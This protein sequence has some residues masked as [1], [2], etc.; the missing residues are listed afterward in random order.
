M[1]KPEL[2]PRRPWKGAR[3]VLGVTGG[4]AAYKSV[5][6]ARDLSRLGAT[7]QVVQS[8]GSRNFVQPLSFEAVTGRPVHTDLFETS[9]G[10]SRSEPGGRA[11]GG[12]ALHIRLGHDADVVC[13]APATADFLARAGTGRAD[14]LLTTTLLVTRAPVVLCPAMNDRMWAHPSTTSNVAR[15]QELGYRI[16]GPGVGPLAYG[17]GEGPGRMLEPAE[18]VEQVGRALCAGDPLGGRRVLVTAGPTREPVDA[19][20]YVGNRSSGRMGFAVARA[21]WRRGADVML[22]TGPS[23]LGDP[24]GVRVVRVESAREMD[25]A[26]RE[27]LPGADVVVFAAAVADYRPRDAG[28]GKLKRSAVGDELTVPLV[29]NPD[30]AAGT[31]EL[32]KPG[33][34]VVGF[35]LE[36]DDAVENARTKLDAKGFDLIV[37]N[38]VGEGTGFDSETTRVTLLSPDGEPEALPLQAKDEAAEAILDRV[39][40]RLEGAGG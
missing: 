20:R 17:E 13:V 28:A 19:V 29:A 8:R 22:V 34:F 30:V 18:I 32:R 24:H 37:A 1:A 33:A 38:E 31:R 40:R 4:V 5:Q 25:A 10:A 23:P 26:V 16:A 35:A 11:A 7:V 3:I 15:C 27:A 39:A 14:D 21:A 6:L 36:T 9:P 12:A 2:S